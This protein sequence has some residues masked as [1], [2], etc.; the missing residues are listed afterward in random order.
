MTKAAICVH[1]WDIISP[2][3]YWETDRRWRWCEC[4]HAAVRW[5]DGYRGLLEVTTL[6]GPDHVRVL[7]INNSFL[8]AAI[9]SGS[10]FSPDEW[11]E[12][13]TAST[14]AV[15]P[16]YLFHKDKRAC[17]ALLIAIGESGDVTY[18]PP[19]EVLTAAPAV[20]GGTA[21][22]GGEA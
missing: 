10:A 5:R 6:H 12:F 20:S 18:V 7:G 14:D 13:H 15:A 11:R 16:N 22:D 8:T 21:H 17:W 2:Y 4:E 1:C 19:G 3:R 9:Q